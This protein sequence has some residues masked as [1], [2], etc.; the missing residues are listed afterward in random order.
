MYQVTICSVEIRW[1]RTPNLGDDLCKK[2]AI[3]VAIAFGFVAHTVPDSTIL[4]MLGLMMITLALFVFYSHLKYA[5]EPAAM[6]AVEDSRALEDTGRR[7]NRYSYRHGLIGVTWSAAGGV[8]VGLAGIG[9]GE[10]ATTALIVRNRL[11]VRVAIGTAVMIVALTVFPA[12][13]VMLTF[14]PPVN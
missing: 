4:A 11:P 1:Y 5:S 9:I 7:T 12:T 6:M 3:P 13:L 2:T 14:F 10:L 8:L